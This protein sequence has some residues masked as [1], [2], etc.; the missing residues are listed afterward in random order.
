MNQGVLHTLKQLIAMIG[1]VSVV[2]S[3]RCHSKHSWSPQRLMP[4][5]EES[6]LHV[7]LDR[8]DQPSVHQFHKLRTYI[9]FPRQ[10]LQ[11][12]SP[13]YLMIQCGTSCE[14]CDP[15]NCDHLSTRLLGR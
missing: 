9:L 15:K 12:R 6:Q 14:S 5:V 13:K 7:P 3:M 2:E 1:T 4:L 8:H 10:Y 11:Q